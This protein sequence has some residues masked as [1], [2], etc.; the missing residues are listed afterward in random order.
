[1]CGTDKEYHNTL[2]G[3]IILDIMSDTDME[4]IVSIRIKGENEPPQYITYREALYSQLDESHRGRF[5]L[6]REITLKELKASEHSAAWERYRKDRRD[7]E[8]TTLVA[9]DRHAARRLFLN[10]LSGGTEA[11]VVAMEL[12]IDGLPPGCGRKY[13]I[14]T[15]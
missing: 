11:L 14:N 15:K 7:P 3:G 12:V 9:T 5:V 13:E 1:M 2:Y 6:A 4:E 10:V 8:G